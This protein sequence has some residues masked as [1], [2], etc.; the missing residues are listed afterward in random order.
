MEILAPLKHIGEALRFVHD[1]HEHHDGTGYPRNLKDEQISIGGKILA[2]ADAFDALTS[3]R[4]Y[5][6]PLT[7]DD[8]LKLLEQHV[9]RLL[10]PRVFSALKSVVGRGSS[11]VFLDEIEG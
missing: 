1:H 3:R 9:G 8:T 6:E 10:D 2:A 7:Q 11:I 4:A 5:R